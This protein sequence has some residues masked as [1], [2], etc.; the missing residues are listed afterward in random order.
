MSNPSHGSPD[1]G[2]LGHAVPLRI[3]VGTWMGLVILTVITVGATYVDLGE[4]NIFLA[5]G[6]AVVK[7][8]IVALY[9]MHLRWDKPF[10]SIVFVSA[11]LFVMLFISLALLDT[12]QY[13]AEKIPGYAPEIE[14][15]HAA[16]AAEPGQA[17]TAGGADAPAGSGSGA[18]ED[19]LAAGH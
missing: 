9:F 14:A 5:M 18:H 6:I 11:A 15:A 16:A 7:S 12:R 3:L 8:T 13:A 17:E 10:H 4:L 19:A 1:H 2:G